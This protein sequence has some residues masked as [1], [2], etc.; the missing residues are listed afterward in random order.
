MKASVNWLLGSSQVGAE[1]GTKAEAARWSDVPVAAVGGGRSQAAIEVDAKCAYYT[2]T[3]SELQ[4][5]KGYNRQKCALQ[6]AQKV[7]SA[8][9][10]PRQFTRRFGLPFS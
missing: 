2:F 9:R 3:R 5:L 1:Q 4:L 8:R 7:R 10:L 6:V